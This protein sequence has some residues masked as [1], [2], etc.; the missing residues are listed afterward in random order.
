MVELAISEGVHAVLLAGDVIDQ[1]NRIFESQ[2]PLKRGVEQLAQAGVVTIA[3]AGNHDA[4]VL[5]QLATLLQDG[6]L[7]SPW[8]RWSMGITSDSCGG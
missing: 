5:P 1:S 3:V 6:R 8:E 2:G 4:K 7:H